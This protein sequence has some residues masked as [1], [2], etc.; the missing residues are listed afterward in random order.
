MD[1][2]IKVYDTLIP[3]PLK[4]VF[5]QFTVHVSDYFVRFLEDDKN[6]DDH[7]IDYL[8]KYLVQ[9]CAELTYIIFLSL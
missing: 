5:E 9:C 1:I 4:L 6:L 7:E 8:S 3:S 2:F